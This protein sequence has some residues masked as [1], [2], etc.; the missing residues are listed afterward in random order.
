MQHTEGVYSRKVSCTLEGEE[1]CK[2]Q[3]LLFYERRRADYLQ[4][5]TPTAVT[6]HK[7]CSLN[8]VSLATHPRKILEKPF[9]YCVTRLD[10]KAA[11]VVIQSP[12]FFISTALDLACFFFFIAL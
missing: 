11:L 3:Q 6:R 1:G 7:G 4:P 2:N 12:V 9:T 5:A 10:S 8:I